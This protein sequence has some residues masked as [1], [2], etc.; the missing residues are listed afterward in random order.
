MPSATFPNQPMLLSNAAHNWPALQR[1][2]WDFFAQMSNVTVEVTDS[3][4]ESSEVIQM[5]D[6]IQHLLIE[7]SPVCQPYASGWR[8]F[9]SF[10][11][12]LADFQEPTAALN[13]ALQLIPSHLLKPLLWLFIGPDQSGTQL[14]YDT[15]LTHAW[16]AVIRGCKRVALH[17]PAIVGTDYQWQREQ[18]KQVLSL[19]QI[20]DQWQFYEIQVGDLLLIPS[21]WWHEVI[22]IG[23]TIGLTRNF[24]TPDIL[25]QVMEMIRLE[26]HEHLL[27]WLIT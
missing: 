5:D 25:P 20:Q 17:P 4:G 26:R 10:P 16:L 3:A 8:F 24:A 7:N 6:Y 14:H 21:A 19:R 1:W 15:L 9:E 11:D 18:A 12:M 23:P 27:P 2:S 22:N 13:D